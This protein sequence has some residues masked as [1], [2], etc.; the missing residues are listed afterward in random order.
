M[1]HVSRILLISFLFVFALST[2]SLWAED[3]YVDSSI[4]LKNRELYKKTSSG[5]DD[6]TR[7]ILYF[8]IGAAYFNNQPDSAFYYY[9]KALN[10]AQSLKRQ[11][12]VA[13]GFSNI[14]SIYWQNGNLDEAIKNVLISTQIYEGLGNRL[15]M[16]RSYGNIGTLYFSIK[17]LTKSKEFTL[18][19]LR[20][21]EDLGRQKEIALCYNNLGSI[22]LDRY[23][24][25]ALQAFM[26]CKAISEEIGDKDL[27]CYAYNNIGAAYSQQKQ[28]EQALSYLNQSVLMFEE[29][30]DKTGQALALKTIADIYIEQ[31]K[32]AE[33]IDLALES[34]A[35][36]N[37]V[38]SLS[39]QS[40]ACLSLS[41]AYEKMRDYKSAFRYLNLANIIGDSI[42]KE[43]G[44]QQMFEFQMQYDVE[45]SVNEIRLLKKDNEIISLAYEKQ[46]NV[47]NFLIT[48]TFLLIV[49]A[50]VTFL[51][52]NEKRKANR[53][54]VKTNVLIRQ[55]SDKLS[56]AYQELD[57]QKS[58]LEVIV[59]QRTVEL[60]K[61][62]KLAEDS[63]EFKS[64][65]LRNVS[66]EIRT[67]L[68]AIMGFSLFLCE[69]NLAKE[70]RD[71]Y[72][73][74]IGQ[75]TNELTNVIEN[76]IEISS[77]EAQDYVLLKEKFLLSDIVSSVVRD[78]KA[79][80]K[81]G[82]QLIY[83]AKTF[84]FCVESDK[85]KLRNII[86][87]VLGN[88]V[89]YTEQG[90]IRLM[91]KITEPSDI[92]VPSV[93]GYKL[94]AR[95]YLVIEIEDSG[96]G[97]PDEQQLKVY[98]TFHRIEVPNSTLYRGMGLGLSI[99]KWLVEL[100][101]GALYHVSRTGGGTSFFIVIP[102][103]KC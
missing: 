61:A 43:A 6:T 50:V 63:N 10:L 52:L 16:A 59:D 96:I 38:G 26:K 33:S 24:E 67:P 55:Q 13:L 17:N 35:L 49:L 19:A 32:L 102:Y 103:E 88:A 64:A 51:L 72:I 12:M 95:Q 47:R 4:V 42:S 30:N 100:M 11:D 60:R 90:V 89:N 83:E 34:L 25:Q 99:S 41:D 3:L 70:D 86:A 29:L 73:E 66:H 58:N 2:T 45:K 48:G 28:Y 9:S 81:K 75:G 76:L 18:K 14:G 93:F 39:S 20:I 80:L 31:N 37:Q 77:L 84:E 40:M 36:S 7:I 94:T 69:D 78:V 46:T 92:S 101:H 79:R 62:K 98:D 54:L 82:V 56:A 23:D 53:A 5:I 85:G 44:M 68:N 87:Q 21:Y 65:I 15:G 71:Q 8:E 97:I 27:R 22:Y 91:S 74:L 1:T 57:D